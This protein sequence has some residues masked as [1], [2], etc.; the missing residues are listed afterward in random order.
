MTSKTI[1]PY[2]LNFCSTSVL[3]SAL[4]YYDI[5]FFTD[6]FGSVWDLKLDI[7]YNEF[8]ESF[9]KTLTIE[10]MA[11][12]YP[13]SL[14]KYFNIKICTLNIDYKNVL[15]TIKEYIDSGD[16]V[17][18]SM[19][20]Y[21]FAH[22]ENYLN[23][24]GLNWNHY[25]IL[26]G[27]DP[28]HNEIHYMDTTRGFIEGYYHKISYQTFLESV[29]P[30][31][32]IYETVGEAYILNLD[33]YKAEKKEFFYNGIEK[34]NE[35]CNYEVISILKNKLIQYKEISNLKFKEYQ[36]DKLLKG[37]I[38]VSQHRTGNLKYLEENFP[39]SGYINEVKEI[40]ELWSR[41]KFSIS[42]SRKKNLEQKYH[43]I[44]KYLDVLE[45]KEKVIFDASYKKY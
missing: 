11:F 22:Y 1:T 37:I 3:A 6:L 44:I 35:I 39:N 30:K 31:D 21:Y 2:P 45:Q 4:K 41:M 27:Y 42:P 5:D 7:Q 34:S 10:P 14:D 15:K 38:L 26:Y 13:K 32:N 40:V 12:N 20:P 43:D 8:L 25:V 17:I 28:I 23:Y 33:S 19:D 29:F 36:L 18:C 24:H 16:I 9:Y